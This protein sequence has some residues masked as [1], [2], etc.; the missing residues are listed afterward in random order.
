MANASTLRL[1][2][3]R[4][5]SGRR[6]LV[7]ADCSTS[8]AATTPQLRRRPRRSPPRSERPQLVLD[9]AEEWI[10]PANGAPP[11][12]PAPPPPKVE[13]P[14]VNTMKPTTTTNGSTKRVLR[15]DVPRG[16]DDNACLRVLEQ[17]HGL[18]E[19]NRGSD[20][21]VL[22]LRDRAGSVIQLEGAE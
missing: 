18:V 10:A 21:L 19:S 5:I 22:L 17:L 16:E 20:E 2:R 6:A 7:R 11:P 13:E 3:R 4:S 8:S 12:R 15:V 9:R 1:R 14:E